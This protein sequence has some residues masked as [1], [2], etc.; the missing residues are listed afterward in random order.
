MVKEDRVEEESEV[1]VWTEQGRKE[2]RMSGKRRE[3]EGAIHTER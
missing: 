1:R 2:G 3:T